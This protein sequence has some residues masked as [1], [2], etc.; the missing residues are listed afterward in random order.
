MFEV[1]GVEGCLT[2]GVYFGLVEAAICPGKGESRIVETSQTGKGNLQV[3]K[4]WL[5]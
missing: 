2:F 1:D 4:F 3:I 5:N